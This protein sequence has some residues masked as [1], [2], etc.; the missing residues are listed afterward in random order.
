M[1]EI[2][3]H[4]LRREIQIAFAGGVNKI[5]TFGVHHVQRIPAF[6]KTPR[7]EIQL[8]CGFDNLRGRK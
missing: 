3:A 6:L 4:E 1:A 7:S 5:A 2:D 8:F